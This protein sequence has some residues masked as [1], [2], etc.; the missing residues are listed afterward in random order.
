MATDLQLEKARG[1]VGREA[2]RAPA[3]HPAESQ[4]ILDLHPVEPRLVADLA[5]GARVRAEGTLQKRPR[6]AHARG[7]LGENPAV[8]LRIPVPVRRGQPQGQLPSVAGVLVDAQGLADLEAQ[9]GR[10]SPHRNRHDVPA[11]GELV[12]VPSVRFRNQP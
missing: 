5:C 10:A 4:T 9:R 7:V 6:R 11:L 12:L 1:V 8:T 3:R 2:Q